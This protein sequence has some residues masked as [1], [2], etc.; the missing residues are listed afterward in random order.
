AVLG[1]AGYMSPEQTRGEKVGPASDLYS[2]GV[3]LYEMLT[4]TLPY[5]ADNPVAQAMMHINE[6]PRSPREANLEVPEPL[7]AITLK[8]LAKNPEDRY[9]SATELADDLK[10]VRSGLP[11]AA[12]DAQ[13]LT[14]A[15][16]T[17][18]PTAPATLPQEQTAKT[19]I[20]PPIVPPPRA[21]RPGGFRQGRLPRVL[22][23]LL[24]GLV[25]LAGLAWVL[26][27]LMSESG[28]S[29]DVSEGQSQANQDEKPVVEE[30]TIVLIPDLVW[31]STAAADLGSAGLYLGA[32]EEVP[33]DTFLAG[34]VI[35][36]NPFEGTEAEA[37]ATVD[38]TVSTGPRQVPVDKKQAQ[39][40]EKQKEKQRQEQ[41]KQAEKQQQAEEKRRERGE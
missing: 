26:T 8:L 25:L 13:K 21:S 17:P 41:E 24:L 5:I 12:V 29:G 28:N 38:I 35:E 7:D 6:P 33:N 9:A 20:R 15:T 23:A 32:V 22:G 4:G 36:T 19:A 34:Q 1:T 30:S 37:G 11:P 27:N 10:Q 39:E 31:Y 40:E 3:V 14:A 2:L 16:T 18:L